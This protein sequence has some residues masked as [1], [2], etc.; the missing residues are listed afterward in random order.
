MSDLPT[1]RA[2]SDLPQIKARL[3]AKG[4]TSA[5]S[6][7]K[8]ELFLACANTLH[9][10]G[11]DEKTAVRAFFVPGR[12]EVLGKHTDYAGGHSIIA[13][14]EK[15]F[16]IV[17]VQ[18]RDTTLQILDVRCAEKVEF[19]IDKQLQ[20][21]TGHW[22]NYPMTVARRIAKN[23]PGPLYGADITFASDLPP[24]AGMAASSAMIVGFFLVLSAANN[25]PSRREYRGNITDPTDLATYLATI[26]N[27]QTFG[28]LV[29]DKGVGTFGGSED[30]TA[31]LCCRAGVLSQYRYCCVQFERDIEF[32]SGHIFAVASSGVVAEKTGAA[33]QE[34]NRLSNMCRR[35][36]EIWN[37]AT[38]RAD[39]NLAAA[40]AS[41]PNAADRLQDVLRNDQSNSQELLKRFEHFLAESE[42]IIPAAAGA[43]A[44]GD[45]P[46]FARGVAR[47]QHLAE[48]LLGN[49]VPE[50]IFLARSALELSAVAASAFGAGFGG[51][52]WALSEAQGAEEFLKE[53]SAIYE[54]HFPK[55]AANA[56][57][58]LTRP[59]PAAFE[60]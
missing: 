21:R 17:A 44:T 8:A 4:L 56:R 52:V 1:L 40:I 24:A 13:A 2:F 22:S 33:M 46:E 5:E 35:I 29:G 54:K 3:V 7:N 20:P 38:G 43:L 57:F 19:Q 28:T 55:P 47:S 34:Y 12:I 48:T 30:H 11:V 42:H 32:P 50:T 60:L 31:I 51:S 26:E 58:F 10:S 23:F 59:G 9:E 16:C 45:L 6:D 27:G 36:V 41:A 15:G 53:W 39:P 37:K 14:T 25:L 49:Q 18:R